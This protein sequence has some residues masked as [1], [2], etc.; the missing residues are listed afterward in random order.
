[1]L[2]V[3]V[4]QH[5]DELIRGFLYEPRLH[6]QSLRSSCAELLRVK[7][8]CWIHTLSIWVKWD[9]SAWLCVGDSPLSCEWTRQ[10]W[11]IRPSAGRP[12]SFVPCRPEWN[13]CGIWW[14]RSP[15][16]AAAP[17]RLRANVLKIKSKKSVI[18]RWTILSSFVNTS[19]FSKAWTLTRKLA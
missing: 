4:E 17:A 3:I 12:D 15:S 1:M 10:W 11:L 2:V 6:L 7:R 5:V 13:R 8:P 18:L 16:S 9:N 14:D 19:N